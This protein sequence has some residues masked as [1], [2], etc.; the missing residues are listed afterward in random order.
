MGLSP[1]IKQDTQIVHSG[2]LS[3]VSFFLFFFSVFSLSSSLPSFLPSL[4]SLHKLNDSYE[5]GTEKAVN[6]IRQ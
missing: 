6:H 2:N 5:S 1:F 4:L 3:L